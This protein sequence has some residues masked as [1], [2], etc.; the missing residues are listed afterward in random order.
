MANSIHEGSSLTL[1]PKR[2]E[3][4]TSHWLTAFTQDALSLGTQARALSLGKQLGQ[5][6]DI[7]TITIPTPHTHNFVGWDQ[8]KICQV[9]SDLPLFTSELGPCTAVLA[10]GFQEAGQV[11]HTALHHV[12]M[13]AE[14][15][16]DTLSALVDKVKKGAI[17]IFISGG[18]KGSQKNLNEIISIIKRFHLKHSDIKFVIVENLFGVCDLQGNPHKKTA[19]KLYPETC[20]LKYAGFNKQQLPFQVV[21]V[22]NEHKLKEP[23]SVIWG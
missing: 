13:D 12:F 14:N 23:Y 1:V 21:D 19:T 16:S 10:R 17:E 6:V 2:T 9:D 20:G 11:S 18:N 3:E 5:V 8:G 7:D 22:T 4:N 15:F